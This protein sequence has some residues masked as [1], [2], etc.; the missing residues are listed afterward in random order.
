MGSQRDIHIPRSSEI[1]L[2]ISHTD[3]YVNLFWD[4]C[5]GGAP[6]APSQALSQILHKSKTSTVVGSRWDTLARPPRRDRGV[7]GA[8]V[9]KEVYIG[10]CTGSMKWDLRRICIYRVGSDADVFGGGA[11][12]YCLCKERSTCP[13]THV[14]IAFTRGVERL[15]LSFAFAMHSR[16]SERS[17]AIRAEQTLTSRMIR[18]IPQAS[19]SRSC[20]GGI[21]NWP[22]TRWPSP[23]PPCPPSWPPWPR[24]VPCDAPLAPPR[25]FCP[26]P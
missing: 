11:W 3:P 8:Q 7:P 23:M 24:R 26:S 17:F 16:C 1:P 22:P 18:G 12:N 14:D 13:A 15:S 9:P 2:K 10:T 4:L 21:R 25:G 20:F 19:E 5:A 6:F